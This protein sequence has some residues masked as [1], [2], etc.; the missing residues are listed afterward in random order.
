MGTLW[1]HVSMVTLRGLLSLH[2]TR[3]ADNPS[4]RSIRRALSSA[5]MPAP[6]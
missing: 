3:S 2:L 6:R 4:D 1:K 5:C